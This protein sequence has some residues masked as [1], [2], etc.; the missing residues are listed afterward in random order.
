MGDRYYLTGAD[1]VLEDD[2]IRAGSIIIENGLIAAINPSSVGKAKC[3]DLNGQ[4]L[5]PGLVDLHCDALEKEVEPRPNTFFSLDFACSQAE[6]RNLFSGISTVFHAISFAHAELGVRNNDFAASIVRAVHTLSSFGLL[7]HRVHCRYEVTDPTGPGILLDLIE[8][9]QVHLLSFMDHT[10][11]QGQFKDIFA[12]RNYLSR[13]YSKTD[14]ELDE[15]ISLKLSQAGNVLSNISLLVNSIKNK[16][17]P[18]ASHDDDCCEKVK[19]FSK[20]GA[21]IS[22]F[23]INLDAARA[24]RELG[25]ITVFGAPN[26]L[27]GKS[28]S[29]SV[30][31]LDAVV[32]GLADCLCSDYHPGSLLEAAFRLPELAGLTLPEAIRLVSLNPAK[33][34]GLHD[35]GVIAVGKRADLVSVFSSHNL[36]HVCQ[37]FVSGQPVFLSPYNRG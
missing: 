31:A 9:D 28:Q 6:K 20:I 30:R 34:S 2:V 8:N 26:I 33:A 25:M 5:I 1:I 32:N 14:D 11:G 13:S 17:I 27:R 16:N 36:V 18:I 21:S 3:I 24:A 4:I 29:G 10:P 19:S 7:D 35:R 23:P 12:Y 15:L 22:E 37:M